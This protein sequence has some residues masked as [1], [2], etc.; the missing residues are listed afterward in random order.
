[1]RRLISAGTIALVN[2]ASM[3]GFTFDSRGQILVSGDTSSN[4]EMLT[5]I[6]GS[7]ALGYQALLTWP[8]RLLD[9]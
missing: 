7:G 3:Q 1:M 8:L 9:G 4:K 6:G 5:A 2:F